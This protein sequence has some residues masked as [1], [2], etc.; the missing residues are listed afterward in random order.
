MSHDPFSDRAMHVK[1][2]LSRVLHPNTPS[3]MVD[4]EAVASRMAANVTAALGLD[5]LGQETVTE[6][7][8]HVGLNQDDIREAVHLAL[9][10]LARDA[11][12]LLDERADE[13]SMPDHLRA[14]L[15]RVRQA[16]EHRVHSSQGKPAAM[17]AIAARAAPADR[18]RKR[19]FQ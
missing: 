12:W 5:D 1:R 3:A 4:G 10:G 6:L 7:L 11:S 9:R 2:V 13:A 19:R 15:R 16:I 17:S 8:A 18:K 14:P